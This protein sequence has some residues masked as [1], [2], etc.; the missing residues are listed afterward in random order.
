MLLMLLHLPT[1]KHHT[2]CTHTHA[3]VFK[4][5]PGYC[6]LMMV[7]LLAQRFHVHLFYFAPF[8]SLV[9]LNS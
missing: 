9:P 7:F 2:N 6:L 3:Y 1:P 8:S 5:D 4:L